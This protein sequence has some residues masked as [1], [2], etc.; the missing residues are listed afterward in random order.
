MSIYTNFDFGKD[1]LLEESERSKQNSFTKLWEN[2]KEGLEVVDLDKEFAEKLLENLGSPNKEWVLTQL[3]KIKNAENLKS[4]NEFYKLLLESPIY[5][6]F[7]LSK[8]ALHPH[9]INSL[10]I[11]FLIGL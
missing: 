10:K 1:Y 2:N 8:S 9:Q 7:N 3:A 11:P 6:E 5:S 4:N